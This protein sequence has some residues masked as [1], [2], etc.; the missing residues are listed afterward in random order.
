[1]NRN[2]KGKQVFYNVLGAV[3][4]VFWLSLLAF[5]VIYLSLGILL[6]P[7]LTSV[8]TIG[9]EIIFRQYDITDSV[10]KRFF[11]G[12]KNNMSMLRYFPLQ[13]LLI[14]E[15]AGLYAANMT[16]MK[17]IAYFC[18]ALM[19]LML[20]YIIY[21]ALCKVHFEQKCDAVTVAVIMVYS[22]PFMISVWLVMTLV[23]LFAGPAAMI[24]SLAA[25]ALLLLL[26]QGTALVGILNFKEKTDSLTEEEK[27]IKGTLF[28][29]HLS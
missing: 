2:K 25:G 14:L 29:A 12:V 3:H 21:T 5:G 24:V 6:L 1:M 11:G 23:C 13:I 20:T 16:G 9:K 22:L 27:E 19:S 15:G 17:V 28:R 10:F 7:V 8:F 4:V 26:I 18:T